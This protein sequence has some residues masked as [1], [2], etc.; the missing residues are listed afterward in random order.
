MCKL[1]PN[2]DFI[3]NASN[4]IK[5]VFLR[6]IIRTNILNREENLNVISSLIFFKIIKKNSNFKVQ[7]DKS[8]K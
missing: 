3:N 7:L 6:K 8:L 2:I 4:I 5:E 1:C